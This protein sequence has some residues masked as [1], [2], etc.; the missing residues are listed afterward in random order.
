MAAFSFPNSPSVNQ[1]HTENGVQWKW[2]G[3]VWKRVESVGPPG[4]PGPGGTGPAGPPGP[5]G[6]Q[7]NQG[8]PG[9]QGNQGN[10]GNQG[11]QGPEGNFGGVSFDYTYDATSTADTDPN[12][13]N[14]KFNN[15]NLSSAGWLYID[16]ADNSGTNIENYLRTIDDSTSSV[17]GHIRISDK[18]DSTDFTIFR[19]NGSAVEASGYH[20]IPVVYLDGDT[21]YSDNQRLIIT[22][23]R[24]GDKGDG[25]GAGNPGPAGPPGP[26]GPQ[27]PQGPPGPQGNQGA[28]GP[29]GDDGGS[30]PPGPPGSGGSAGPPGPAG[31]PGSDGDDGGS[32]PPGPPGSGGP[33]G[34]P[35]SGG[36]GGPPGPP[37]PQGNQGGQGGQ[38]PPGPQGNQGGQGSQGSQGPPGPQGNQGPPGPAGSTTY[39]VPQGGIIIWSGSTGSIPSGWALC[40]GS[41]ATPDLRN[42]FV[43]GAGNSYSVGAQGGSKDSVIVNHNHTYGTS[44]GGAGGHQHTENAYRPY[45]DSEDSDSGWSIS[46]EWSVV[47]N[48]KNIGNAVGNHA[49][50]FSGT[51][52]SAS[53]SVNGGT[54]RNLPPYYALCY[55]MKT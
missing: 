19:L 5:Q 51:T 55:I 23:A 24:T 46:T 10:Q 39:A 8:P 13:G 27:G 9:P 52:N 44:T 7:G 31:S 49:H 12:A 1:T 25:G 48:N 15:T 22:F 36:S 45:Y 47:Q 6:N 11:P 34:P 17:K 35:G 29:A 53:N 28:Q 21:S 16:D 43:V 20:K 2:N 30:G 32:G 42:R 18:S 50:S 40:N 38:G 33:P 4:P 54:N 41:N 14:L 3:T 37:G 26:Q